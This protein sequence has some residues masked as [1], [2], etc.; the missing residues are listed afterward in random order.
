[1]ASNRDEL[2]A[3]LLAR[4]EAAI[5]QLL[6]DERLHERMTLSEIEAVVGPPEATFRQAALEEVIALQ[7]SSAKTCPLCGGALANKGKRPK[8]VVTVRGETTIERTYYHCQ[9]CEQGYFP[10]R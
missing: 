6:K 2:K 7:T 8:Q 1:M 9:R 3:A 10:P 4:A 5:E